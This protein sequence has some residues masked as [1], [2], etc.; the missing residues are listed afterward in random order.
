MD[1]VLVLAEVDA[2]LG[3]LSDKEGEL[4]DD[5]HDQWPVSP[6]GRLFAEDAPTAL[7]DVALGRREDQGVE[8]LAVHALG[9][10]GKGRE[11]DLFLFGFLELL[12]LEA[13]IVESGR[14]GLMLTLTRCQRIQTSLQVSELLLAV[15]ED[16]NLSVSISRKDHPDDVDDEGGPRLVRADAVDHARNV[17]LADAGD[18]DFLAVGVLL[19]RGGQRGSRRERTRRPCWRNEGGLDDVHGV[20]A[21]PPLVHNV[22]QE[23]DKGLGHAVLSLDGGGEAQGHGEGPLFESAGEDFGAQAVALVDDQDAD[24]RKDVEG[25]LPHGEG[26]DAGQDDVAVLDV[27]SLALD[28][29]D[30]GSGQEFRNSLAPLVQEEVLVDDDQGLLLELG[31]NLERNDGL[32]LAAGER[33]DSAHAHGIARGLQ[34]CSAGVQLLW[35]EVAGKGQ[36]HGGSRLQD[37]DFREPK[38]PESKVLGH[39]DGLAGLVVDGEA[40]APVSS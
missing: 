5:V 32:A 14:Y 17:G 9:C 33:D 39:V 25:V 13:A 31:Q 21:T 26:L 1:V 8:G 4:V 12:G 18:Q 22:P 36:V 27:D 35:A 6:L 29:A 30:P 34:E 7:L 24:A 11:Q 38:L 23:R 37:V 3:G 20:D 16:E 19:L 15:G 28:E 40:S 2:A 10:V